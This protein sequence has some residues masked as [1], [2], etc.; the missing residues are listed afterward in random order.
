MPRSM[1]NA[2]G[3]TVNL[4]MTITLSAGSVTHEV[5]WLANIGQAFEI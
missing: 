2:V 1:A 3:V 4:I 5:D